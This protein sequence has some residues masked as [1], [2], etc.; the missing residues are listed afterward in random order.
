MY[1]FKCGDDFKNKLKGFSISQ[2]NHIKYKE[3][4]NVQMARNIKENVI[5]ILFVR[6]TMKSISKKIKN[7]HY[8]YLMINYIII[9]T[10]SKPCN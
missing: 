2:S 5:I 9:E 3:H 4:K 8:L 1:S 7:Q 10:E 6:L